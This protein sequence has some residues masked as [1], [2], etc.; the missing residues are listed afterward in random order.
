MNI[1]ATIKKD[2]CNPLILAIPGVFHFIPKSCKNT[3]VVDV[4]VSDSGV[5]KR[6]VLTKPIY[7]ASSG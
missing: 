7:C 3:F 1:L 4:F 2:Y 6:H 5:I